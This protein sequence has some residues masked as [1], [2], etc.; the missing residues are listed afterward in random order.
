M[1]CVRQITAM[2]RAQTRAVATDEATVAAT[3]LFDAVSREARGVH[4]FGPTSN[5]AD[6]QRRS[7]LC[8]PR[9]WRE[10][11]CGPLGEGCV[12][13]AVDDPRGASLR[14]DLGAAPGADPRRRLG[15]GRRESGEARAES[16]AALERE[17]A[18]RIMAPDRGSRC[19]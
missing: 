11:A 7:N 13:V 2:N 12:R 4:K 15:M 10:A 5:L 17:A 19:T 14:G 8:T 3:L 1:T 9:P 6:L 16:G 18:V